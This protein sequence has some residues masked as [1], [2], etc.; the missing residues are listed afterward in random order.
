MKFVSY[1][2]ESVFFG[3]F[4]NTFG[5]IAFEMDE[6]F[7]SFK[8]SINS[9]FTASHTPTTRV[10]FVH[11]LLDRKSTF[12]VSVL[13]RMFLYKLRFAGKYSFVFAISQSHPWTVSTF[14]FFRV[15]CSQ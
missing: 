13:S 2:S 10:A 8:F 11:I 6:M 1:F 14:G 15:F 7:C 3:S 9:C 12:L 5:S 4:L